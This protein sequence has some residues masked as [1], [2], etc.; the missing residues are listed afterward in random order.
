MKTSLATCPGDLEWTECGTSCEPICGEPAPQFCTEMCVAGCQCP[1][2]KWRDGNKCYWKSDC[3]G[4][5][6]P[7][8][9]K[10][11]E[12]GTSCEPICG[13]PA[14]RFYTERCVAGCQCPQG[15]WRVGDKCYWKW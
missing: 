9:L 11:T 10:W 6:C 12:C 4:N 5:D 13:E 7:G 8:D 2:G 1:K 14:P 15:K 3:P